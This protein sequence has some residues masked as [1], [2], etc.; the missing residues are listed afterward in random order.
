MVGATPGGLSQKR[1]SVAVPWGGG[2][3]LIEMKN[4]GKPMRMGTQDRN[5]R[6][7]KSQVK[8][9]K[10]LEEARGGGER[11]FPVGARTYRR[12]KNASTSPEGKVPIVHR[13]G[14]G[15][16]Q[17][18]TGGNGRGTPI[19]NAE[20]EMGVGRIINGGER[21]DRFPVEGGGGPIKRRNKIGKSLKK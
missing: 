2:E 12:S 13:L 9:P 17:G 18:R 8:L 7:I 1:E 20:I 16:D 14:Q 15:E 11:A 5:H 3:H 19:E 4:S 10:T 6:G 21:E